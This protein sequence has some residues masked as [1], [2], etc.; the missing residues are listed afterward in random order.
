MILLERHL[1]YGWITMTKDIKESYIYKSIEE[2]AIEHNLQNQADYLIRLIVG[3]NMKDID[4]F[5]EIDNFLSELSLD[6]TVVFVPTI[7]DR[8]IEFTKK[9]DQYIIKFKFKTFA[10]MQFGIFIYPVPSEL[11]T[12]MYKSYWNTIS[13]FSDELEKFNEWLDK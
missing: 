6:C 3:K 12:Y 5:W 4:S 9:I 11:N 1:I 13:E 10:V 7:G 8:I 2:Y